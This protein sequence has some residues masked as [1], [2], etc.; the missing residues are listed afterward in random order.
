MALLRA[1]GALAFVVGVS[2]L[3]L[4]AAR[5]LKVGRFEPTSLESFWANLGGEGIFQIR[6]RLSYWL[7]DAADQ[8]LALPACFVI[9]GL[10][11]ALLLATDGATRERRQHPIAL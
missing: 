8:V 10:G 11:M 2:L 6:Y 3:A 7:G 4:D 1:F 9:F 5:S